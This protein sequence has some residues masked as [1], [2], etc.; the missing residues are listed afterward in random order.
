MRQCENGEISQF[1]PVENNNS[2]T[3]CQ[4]LNPVNLTGPECQQTDMTVSDPKDPDND[5]AD[6]DKNLHK[7]QNFRDE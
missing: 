3:K 1:S 7:L 2:M 4:C 5:P 6:S